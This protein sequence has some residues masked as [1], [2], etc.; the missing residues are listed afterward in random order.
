MTLKLRRILVTVH[1]TR[2]A[3]L[4]ALRSAASIARHTGAA[5]ELF[6][7]MDHESV[8]TTGES[9]ESAQRRLERMARSAPLRGCRVRAGVALGF[10]PH[11]QIVR[12]AS[13][14]RADL[15]V[16]GYHSRGPARRLF[17]R[18]TDWELIRYCPCPLLLVKTPRAY[19]RPA[20]LV[21]VDPFHAH[22]KPARLDD[23]LLSAGRELGRVLHGSVHAFHAYMPLVAAV[24]GPL[25]EPLVWESPT[26]EDV[27]GAQVRGSFD[28]LMEKAGIPRSRRH[29]VMGDVANELDLAVRRL[30]ANI[31]VMGAVSRSGLKRLLIGSTAERVLDRLACDV[32]VVKPRGARVAH[33]ARGARAAGTAR[34]AGMARAGRAGRAGRAKRAA[35]GRVAPAPA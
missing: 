6:H 18:N 11:E 2:R 19:R 29:L 1:D 7:V 3:P 27:H 22:A 31:V 5:I 21:A 33:P 28:R 23:R 14:S 8:A 30:R 24:E 4:A 9:P 15:V 13:A 34:A 35:A 10:P 17:L 12:R 26:I 16:A 25:G 32:L 20:I